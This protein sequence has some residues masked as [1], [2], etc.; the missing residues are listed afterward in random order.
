M[1][2]RYDEDFLE[3]AVGLCAGGRRKGVSPLHIARFSRERER[4]YAILDPDERNAAF[5]KLHLEWF[6]E[7][8]L[9]MLL[10]GVLR[11][12]PLLPKTLKLLAFRKPHGR[13]DEGAELYVSEAGDRNGVVAMRPDRFEQEADLGSFLRHELMH[14]HDMVDPGF[15]YRPELAVP[16]ASPNQYRSA[17]ERYRLLWDISIEGRLN[18][19]GRH[20]VSTRELLCQEFATAFAFW[21]EARQQKV[22]GS[23][24]TDPAPTHR[25]FEELAC[26][27]RHVQCAGGPQ[28]GSLC[29]LCGFPTF[30]WAAPS[31]LVDK[32]PAIQAEFP[33]WTPQ[34]GA[35]R[36]C[37]A[38]YRVLASQTP[39]AV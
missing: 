36:R 33:H 4:L 12:Y 14:L 18:H 16:S 21:A 17:R 1:H 3:A 2:L 29:P 25:L 31:S 10:T 19:A 26:D 38:I 24:W 5:F 28:P 27:P 11:E 9:E 22:F 34:Q 8:G 7:W 35:C 13:N 39:L 6:R 32:V 23:L 15:G 30:D 37:C 20:G